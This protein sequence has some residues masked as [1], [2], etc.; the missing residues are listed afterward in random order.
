MEAQL[1]S[2]AFQEN[3][4][5]CTTHFMYRAHAVYTSTLRVFSA[6]TITILTIYTM[7]FALSFKI[8]FVIPFSVLLSLA[9]FATSCFFSS[10]EPY[11]DNVA[12]QIEVK[13]YYPSQTVSTDYKLVMFLSLARPKTTKLFLYWRSKLS[14][15][16]WVMWACN[17]KSSLLTKILLSIVGSYREETTHFPSSSSLAFPFLWKCHPEVPYS[18]GRTQGMKLSRNYK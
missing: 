16:S 3:C 8:V 13:T 17:T 11:W 12:A 18:I 7:T 6:H 4:I 5:Y 2:Q 1:C 15:D 10:A 9:P 14:L